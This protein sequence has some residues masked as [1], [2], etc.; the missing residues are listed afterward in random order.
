MREGLK[1][2]AVGKLVR[3]RHLDK[4]TGR[5]AVGCYVLAMYK[6]LPALSEPT[7][8]DVSCMALVP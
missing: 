3:K 7:T 6:K 4:D 2:K 5:G 8:P 1:V